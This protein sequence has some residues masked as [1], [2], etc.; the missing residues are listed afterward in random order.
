[1]STFEAAYKSQLQ[2]VSQ[3]LPEERLP[4]QVTAQVNMVSDPVTNVRRRPGLE[5]LQNWT[6]PGATSDTVIGWFTDVAGSR[7]HVYLN[8]ITGNIRVYDEDFRLEASLDAGQ[9]LQSSNTS[10]IRATTVRNEFFIAN[11]DKSPTVVY[12]TKPTY[13]AG[14]FYV[15]S[16]AFSKTY[17]LSVGWDGVESTTVS[18][19]TPS[20]T[21]ANDAA[22][23]TPENIA[24][25]LQTRM[26]AALPSLAIQRQGPYLYLRR[27]NTSGMYVS[28]SSGSG[29]A[30]S[31]RGGSVQ[32]QGNLPAQLPPGANG[33]IIRV[34]TGTSPQYFKYVSASVEWVETG[35]PGSP[36]AVNGAPISLFWNGSTWELNL[37]GFVGREAGDDTSN[38]MHEW[39]EYGITGMG[40]YQGRLV[41]MSGP[42]V[43]L[44]E[45]G[46]P[47]NF[48]R[49]TTTSV[50]SSDPIEVGSSMNSAAAYEWAVPFQKD[51][52]LFSAAYQAV[53]PSG[54]TALTPANAM[55]VA[56]STHECD[57]TSAPLT[58]GRTVLYCTPR[59]EKFFGAM[60]MIPSNYTDSQYVSQDTTAHLPKYMAGRC[61]FAV[62]SGV[63]PLALFA[64]SGD[65]KTLL[66]HEYHWDGDSKVQ[67]A[68]HQWT[69]PYEICTAYFASD[70]VNV[71]FV[72]NGV[73]VVCSMDV[74]AGVSS[75][76]VRQPFLDMYVRGL[77]Q[78]G[79][80]DIPQWMIQFDPDIGKEL[81][82][83]VISGPLAGEE[84][85]SSL[86]QDGA[87][88]VT[89][90]SYPAGEVGLGLHFRSTLIPTPPVIRDYNDAII[91]SGK[92]TLH[93]MTVGTRDSQL[94][95]VAVSDDYTETDEFGLPTLSWSSPELELG[96][97]RASKHAQCSIPCRTD[98]RTSVVEFYCEGAG[99]MNIVSLEYTA[100]FHP[101]VKRR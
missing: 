39:V 7:V 49:T 73:V 64:P 55:V 94:F 1:M 32:A 2:G 40:T 69:F 10:R 83:E 48:F 21:G 61:R 44:S 81:R 13:G 91:H 62:A 27:E 19:T 78:G 88:L 11:L 58:L 65:R 16:G 20:G 95:N 14:F 38:P 67:Q 89:V 54:N 53:I 23:A 93:R 87:A 101:K 47:R 77:V 37:S 8:T 97:E 9:Y 56:T 80:I 100:K 26:L 30:I 85:G 75:G 5:A 82:L 29:Y 50:I 31:S 43:S 35:A 71:V 74:K 72:R 12:N 4:G 33:Y 41:L 45:S 79:S 34:G 3:Q 46:K 22:A 42:M 66:V 36:S 70:R 24:A 57:T 59:S 52:L 90:P 18:F 76:S 15:V 51:L 17:D 68:W 84:V 60:E 25:Q 6:W 92:A 96:R 86:R 28:T 98:L 63:A 99:E